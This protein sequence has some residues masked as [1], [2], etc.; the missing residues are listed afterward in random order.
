MPGVV[1]AAAI[2]PGRLG[3]VDR[4]Q[5]LAVAVGELEQGVEERGQAGVGG[6]AGPER[7]RSAQDALLEVA[8]VLV[9]ERPDEP[10]AITEAM[11]HGALGHAGGTGDLGGR[12]GDDAALGHEPPGG[13]Q[14]PLPVSHRV[15][16]LGSRLPDH[17]QQVVGRDL[18]HGASS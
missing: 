12:H 8:L 18:G 6:R 5:Q 13:G 17:R 14:D 15:G 7:G 16:P 3:A 2:A 11:E 4:Q 10:G 9:E 1:G